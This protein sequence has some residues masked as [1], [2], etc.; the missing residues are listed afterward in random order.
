[1]E[2]KR[3]AA[4][5]CARAGA[6]GQRASQARPQRLASVP[7]RRA[8]THLAGAAL[9]PHPAVSDGPRHGVHAGPAGPRRA[10]LRAARPTGQHRGQRRRHLHAA[11]NARRAASCCWA[12]WKPG[13]QAAARRR[14]RRARGARR[15]ARPGPNDHEHGGKGAAWRHAAPGAD[16]G[17]P[18]RRGEARLAHSPSRRICAHAPRW[19]GCSKRLPPR[20]FV[21]CVT[22]A[23]CRWPSSSSCSAARWS[24]A[25]QPAPRRP[26]RSCPS[27]PA[28]R[29]AASTAGPPHGRLRAAAAGEAVAPPHR[30]RARVAR[31]HQ[32][33]RSGQPRAH[34]G[35]GLD[36]RHVRPRRRALRP[37]R[38]PRPQRLR[39]PR[40]NR[41]ARLS[42]PGPPPAHLSLLGP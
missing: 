26:T 19:P 28:H 15:A 17:A 37:T 21:S 9:P 35:R 23:S 41:P 34:R 2:A 42:P 6:R 31:A 11:E 39:R 8:L 13:G 27:S 29:A 40:R 18:G 20:S 10:P 7:R 12:A 3:T 5:P 1:M 4:I 16:A 38:R 32:R 25:P 22:C 36:S 14:R 24:P 33:K 30:T